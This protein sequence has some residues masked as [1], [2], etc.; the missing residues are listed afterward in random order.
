MKSEKLTVYVND[1]AKEFFI[2][3]QVRHAIGA[4]WTRRVQ[5]HHALVRDQEGNWLDVDGPLYNGM[6]LYL[7]PTTPTEFADAVQK[8]AG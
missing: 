4:R 8:R 3:L 5:T 7:E 2:G 1:R 6:R